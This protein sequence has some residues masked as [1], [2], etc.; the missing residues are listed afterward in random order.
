M[1]ISKLP[2]RLFTVFHGVAQGGLDDIN[3]GFQFAA[4]GFGLEQFRLHQR[5]LLEGGIETVLRSERLFGA[6]ITLGRKVIQA[7][8]IGAL[9][10]LCLFAEVAGSDAVHQDHCRGHNGPCNQCGTARK[11]DNLRAGA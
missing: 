11:G 8:L 7:R 3:A 4:A 1:Q 5:N 6:D 2:A 10:A 9:V